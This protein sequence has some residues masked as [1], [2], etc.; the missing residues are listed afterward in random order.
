MREMD[1]KMERK[2]LVK[3]GDK[4][5]VIEGVLPSS[6]YYTIVPAVA[7]SGNFPFSERLKSTSGIVKEVKETSKGFYVTVEF[8]E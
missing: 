8:D 2:D 7:M 3:A 4:V 1:F 6:Y 5:D